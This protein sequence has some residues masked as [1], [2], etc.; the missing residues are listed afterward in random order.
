[1]K[2][3]LLIAILR[4]FVRDHGDQDVV[5]HD[6]A[7]PSDLCHAGGV[8]VDD[9]EGGKRYFQIYGGRLFVRPPSKL[10]KKISRA[11]AK[12]SPFLSCLKANPFPK[13]D[14][15]RKPDETK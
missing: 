9:M 11:L 14:K 10:A 8:S 4:E 6:G 7:D 3:T 13:T 5:V 15:I 12:N 1:M 2:A